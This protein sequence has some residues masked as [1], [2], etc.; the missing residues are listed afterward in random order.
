M[1]PF[2]NSQRKNFRCIFNSYISDY[3][4]DG[5]IRS[6][7]SQFEGYFAEPEITVIDNGFILSIVIGD[8]LSPTQVRDKILWNQFIDSVTAA[9]AIRK[10]QI[11]RLPKAGKENE[12]TV[13][14]FGPHGSISGVNEVDG[15]PHMEFRID[16]GDRPD[17]PTLAS[18]HYADPTGDMLPKIYGPGAE[19]GEPVDEGIRSDATDMHI[20]TSH[21][22]LFMGFKVVSTEGSKFNDTGS[23]NQYGIGLGNPNV[24]LRPDV[25]AAERLVDGHAYIPQGNF[26][27]TTRQQGSVPGFQKTLGDSTDG[28]LTGFSDKAIGTRGFKI[29]SLEKKP[30]VEDVESAIDLPQG[31]GGTQSI[32]DGGQVEGWF[33]SKN[34]GINET[35]GYEGD[36]DDY[37]I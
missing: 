3:N 30:K 28:M 25:D 22:K 18:V 5:V 24:T 21:P 15:L 36:I 7:L 27:N 12:G 2:K 29:I 1:E 31:R 37:D 34:F 9:D 6:I 16:M 11:I 13:G 8:N 4:K 14:G 17:G 23:E 32:P 20:A 35:Y 10:I 33:D 26:F 19:E